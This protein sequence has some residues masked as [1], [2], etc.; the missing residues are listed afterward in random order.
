MTAPLILFLGKPGSGKGTQAALLSEK[1]GYAIFKSSGQLRELAQAYPH[2]GK[3]ILFA[4]DRGD[5]VPY[6]LPMHLWLEDILSLSEDQGIIIDGAVRRVEEATLFDEVA[7]WFG[8]PYRVFFLN[9]SDEEM[10]KRIEKRATT[11]GRTDDNDEALRERM[12]EFEK[13]TARALEFF[14]SEG[15]YVE[16]N[17]EGSIEDIHDRVMEAF[18]SEFSE[19]AHG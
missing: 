14:K 2:I 11:E 1:T 17:G 16:I 18:R 8:R 3:K 19:N 15:T 7:E 4:M 12:A 13:H 6:W 9:V 10:Q 5:L